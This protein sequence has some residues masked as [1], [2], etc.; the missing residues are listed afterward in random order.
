MDPIIKEFTKM[1]KPYIETH[2]NEYIDHVQFINQCKSHFEEI[3]PGFKTD[4]LFQILFPCVCGKLI[5]EM[6]LKEQ[7][8]IRELKNET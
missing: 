6:R 2:Y 4:V 5:S 8:K 3:A 1:I 7:Q